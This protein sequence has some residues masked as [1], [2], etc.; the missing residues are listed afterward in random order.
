MRKMPKSWPSPTDLYSLQK[1]S[2]VCFDHSGSS[3][4]GYS[5]WSRSMHSAA[6]TS[7]TFAESHA[8][9]ATLGA[10]GHQRFITVATARRR[11]MMLRYRWSC[12]LVRFC[13]R[14]IVGSD[15]R[16]EGIKAIPQGCMGDYRETNSYVLSHA[17]GGCAGTRFGED[18]YDC[19]VS[20]GA[21]IN[22]VSS[23]AGGGCAGTRF[24]ECVR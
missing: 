20:P 4:N 13:L 1:D 2:T 3:C 9:L 11:W 10:H 24:G 18:A 15:G 22:S 21:S 16:G 19:N 14:S 5:R 8:L 7:A 23:N 12:P 6:Q 17:G